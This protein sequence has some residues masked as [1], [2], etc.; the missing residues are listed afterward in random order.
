M[1]FALCLA[2]GAAITAANLAGWSWAVG[3]MGKADGPG[4]L[5]L[6]LF[7]TLKLGLTGLALYFII[8]SSWLDLPGLLIGVGLPVMGSAALRL[9][10]AAKPQKG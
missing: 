8:K 10:R 5:P 4:L 7:F 6:L 3:R 1:N 2:A 9:R